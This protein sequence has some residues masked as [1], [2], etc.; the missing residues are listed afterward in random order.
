M[1]TKL[2]PAYAGVND[3]SPREK[4]VISTSFLSALRASNVILSGA[5]NPLSAGHKVKGVGSTTKH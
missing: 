5:K 1:L 3:A 2:S 4:I